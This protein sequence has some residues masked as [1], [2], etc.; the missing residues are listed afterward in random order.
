MSRTNNMSSTNVRWQLLATVSALALTASACASQS[1]AADN[2]SDRPQ[3]W[4]E[5]GGQLSRLDDAVEPFT[6]AFMADV[7][8]PSLLSALDV[9]SQ[10]SNAFDWDGK[11]SFQPE[12]GDWVFAA[13]VKFGRSQAIE[14]RHQ[15]TKNVPIKE[16]ISIPTFGIGPANL[17][18][19][20]ARYVRFADGQSQQSERHLVLDFQ[21]GKDVG[22]GMFGGRGSSVFSAGVR[23]AQFTSKTNVRLGVIP[24]L[25][26]PTYL[27]GPGIAGLSDILKY[28]PPSFHNFAAQLSG[29]RSFRGL[30][31][32]LAWNGSVPFAGDADSGELT[33]DWGANAALLFG[34]QKAS[35]QS[36][37]TART[38]ESHNWN[39][40]AVPKYHGAFVGYFFGGS[41]YPAAASHVVPGNFNRERTVTVPNLGGSVGISF[42]YVD[43]K[44]SFGYKADF[45]FNAIDG[46]I[47]TRKSENRGFFGPYASISIGLGD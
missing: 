45:F 42:R 24:D 36:Q 4:I 47:A 38:P 30:G 43:A 25:Q 6:P 20:P 37:T 12:G 22:L 27:G 29:E 40:K 17:Y 35:G 9:Q 16:F 5:L 18:K 15:Q 1:L 44:V 10:P 11:L 14:H 31:P 39:N 28:R 33:F 8:R 3:I 19:Y 41:R 26:Y 46:G 13:S 34:R 32:S 23:Y 7:T 2:D 21:A